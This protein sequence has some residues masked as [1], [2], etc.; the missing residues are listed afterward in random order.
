MGLSAQRSTGVLRRE[1]H[2]LWSAALRIWVRQSSASRSASAFS[3]SSGSRVPASAA[4][5]WSSGM[6]SSGLIVKVPVGPVG[7]IS[8]P[9]VAER[10]DE[11]V[12]V[13]GVEEGA[14]ERLAARRSRSRRRSGCTPRWRRAWPTPRSG[15]RPRP[16][17][18]C[19]VG[20]RR[21]DGELSGSGAGPVAAGSGSTT[22][23]PV[24]EDE[25][26]PEPAV[27]ADRLHLPGVGAGARSVRR[28]V[29]RRG[30]GV[31]DGAAAGERDGDPVARRAGDRAP[32]Q[33]RDR[34][35]LA[36]D[37]RDQGRA[38]PAGR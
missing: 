32:A 10:L 6:T 23:A 4:Y 20:K 27:L 16:A 37:R 8:V 34:D 19:R 24:V 38:R 29:R 22:N 33:G 28:R 26:R 31:D 3:G 11:P 9:L 5:C 18:S 25:R 17:S 36:V 14:V 35:V 13:T 21:P 15:W 1:S 7:W 12:V 30:G 2:S